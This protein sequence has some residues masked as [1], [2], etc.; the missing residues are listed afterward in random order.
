MLGV[1]R[2]NE[3]DKTLVMELFTLLEKPDGI[4]LRTR[5]FTPSLTPWEKSGASSLA[6]TSLD[7]KRAVFENLADGNPARTIITRI[8]PDTFI[9]RAE[10]T[11]G[12]ET[13]AT[14]ITYHREK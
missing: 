12:G 7:Q 9:S 14:E 3:S 5:H 8:D 10:I 11:T 1:L 6:L 4:E 13:Q 2:L